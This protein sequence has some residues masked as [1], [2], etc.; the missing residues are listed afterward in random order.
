MDKFKI[1]GRY[2]IAAIS[3]SIAFGLS[4]QFSDR[5]VQFDLRDSS[6]SAADGDKDEHDLSSLKIFNRVLLRIKDNYV[7]PER[8][9]ANE[10]LISSLDEVQNAIPPVVVDFGEDKDD[11]P[12]KLTV[13]VNGESQDFA[14]GE[15]E[16]LWEMSFRLQK[17]FKFIEENLEPSDDLDFREIEYA[18]INGMLKTLD[19]HSSLLPP[20]H[21]EEM[22]TQ[23]GGEFG[24]LGIQIT[25][26]DGE[27]TVIS[28]IEDTPASKKGIKAED[29]IVR[30]EDESTVN[31][32]LNEA[33]EKMRGE[34]GTEIDLWISRKKW[35][36]P[37]K[38]TI[39]RD[40]INIESVDSEPLSDKVGYLRIKNFQQNTHS[41][42]VKELDGLKE[43]MGG[44]QGLVLDMRD[45]PGGLLD[46]AIKV[47]DTF[48]N[49][50]TIVSTV[51]ADEE[52]KD[53]KV[54]TK[55]GTEPDYPIM[56]L[57][58][59]GSASAS[60]IVAGALQNHDRA[61]VIGDTTFGKGSVQVLYEFDDNSALKLTVAQYLTPGEVS[62]QSRGI[63]PDL[64]VLPTTI[65]DKGDIDM[66]ASDSIVR[67]GD[68]DSH[69]SNT[70]AQVAGEDGIG[71]VR[72]YDEEAENEDDEDRQ[73][74]DP[75]EFVVDFN[76]ELAQKLLKA[77]GEEYR[78]DALLESLQSELDS[79]SDEQMKEIE[80]QLGQRN[81]DWAEGEN[82]ED[83]DVDLELS[84][85]SEDNT[86]RAGDKVTLTAKLTNNSDKPLHR[87][88][89][90]SDSANQL[91]DDHEFVFGKIEPGETKEWSVEVEVPRDEL[92]RHDQIDFRVSGP[93]TTFGEGAEFEQ[94]LRI[95]GRE[96]PE[97]GFDYEIDDE[98]GDGL[99][100]KG[101]EVTLRTTVKNI[102]EADS[103]ETLVYLK[104][105][106]GDAIYL[107]EGRA[108][109]ED[110]EAGGEDTV[111]FSFEV[112]DAP[113]DDHF[114]LEIDVFDNVF[115]DFVHKGFKLPFASE[116]TDVENAQGIA[117]VSKDG[118]K[119]HVAPS[120]R[121][122]AIGTAEAEAT[123]PV[124]GKLGDWFRV[125]L[126]ERSAWVEASKVDHDPKASGS[127]AG[128]SLREHFQSPQV[129]L[130]PAT[131]MTEDKSVD[132]KGSITDTS[133]IEDYYIRVLNR[134]D[135][136][137]FNT[138]K[139]DYTRGGDM[140]T[141]IDSNVPLFPGMNRISV[142]VRD[143]DDMETTQDVFVYRS[144][145]E[146]DK[147]DD[148]GK[149]SAR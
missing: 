35:S 139:L 88:K 77:A 63:S 9:D 91:F 131:M 44:M 97:Y 93:D 54:A 116:E 137:D 10:M 121:A 142:V 42:M 32:D 84:T 26:R 49:E 29:H 83:A 138:R 6:A 68:L 123:L 115:R 16:S 66:F 112:K 28:P 34:P 90:V 72:Y 2:L 136:T 76:I 75:D 15:L 71:F 23:T 17:I 36:E 58:N 51:G 144:S 85:S 74:R 81:I 61:L 73:M 99:L 27:L 41:D 52:Q 5:G 4:V 18:A 21:F 143:A 86:V 56:V 111:E 8:I 124:E 127:V 148:E 50:G 39:E 38:F 82:P 132:L 14:V 100:E 65:H 53:E 30:I 104:N 105:K 133:N 48:L 87:I 149:A 89:A 130:E 108:T 145:G 40:I 59:A 129:E 125:D 13:E 96:R 134:V 118:T 78:R 147:G 146:P 102:G 126:E 60:E 22:Q 19:P 103:E 12:S 1:R 47:S 33:V 107:D 80:R 7:E 113:E 92:S 120:D 37:R 95:T 55:A 45:N 3:L 20:E 43:E 110:I 94:A 64:Q 31:M 141:D 62:I 67:E 57:V 11:I 106:S 25:I 140:K 135:R 101:E 128:V 109:I 114:E 70:A 122:D 119:L 46:Q 24:G 69:L 117:K 98:D 79:I